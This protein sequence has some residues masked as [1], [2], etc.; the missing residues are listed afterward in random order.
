MSRNNVVD[1]DSQRLRVVFFTIPVIFSHAMALVGAAGLEGS[2]WVREEEGN[3]GGWDFICPSV[4][5]V[6]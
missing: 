4:R 1:S 2:D 6:G 3:Q 5:A